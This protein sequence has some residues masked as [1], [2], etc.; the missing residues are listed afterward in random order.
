MAFNNFLD[1]AKSPK[2]T[3][4]SKK[5]EKRSHDLIT[6]FENK[7]KEAL[8]YLERR[9]IHA[10]KILQKG[11]RTA[12]TGL[13]AAIVLMSG[14]FSH[15]NTL[16]E[17]VT[18]DNFLAVNQMVGEAIGKQDSSQ[19]LL[20][21]LGTDLPRN[22]NY[23]SKESENLL[24]SDI[25]KALGVKAVAELEGNRLNTNY[26]K[27]GLEQHLPRYP[28]DNIHEHFV[29]GVSASIY[30]KSGLTKNRG[31]FGYFAANRYALTDEAIEMEKYYAVVQ[32]FDIPGYNS[33]K[34]QWYK[35]RKVLI[36][37]TENGRA[38]VGAIADSGPAKWTGKSFG[39]SPELMDHLQMYRGNRKAKVLVFFIDETNGAVKLGPI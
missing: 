18:T 20:K 21:V 8:E 6:E 31:A 7:H 12:A 15:E 4:L 13:A 19:A 27:I 28:G 29:S 26:G 9:G 38:V 2:F 5:F 34:A 14:G 3:A 10:D 25:S 32:T 1:K 30:G 37:N 39:G 11:S 24:T 33:K 22:V 36:V 35:H 16:P 23:L 17:P